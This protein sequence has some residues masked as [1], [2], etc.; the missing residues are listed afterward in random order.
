MCKTCVLLYPG[1]LARHY[2][3]LE[4]RFNERVREGEE[5]ELSQTMAVE[6]EEARARYGLQGPKLK[7]RDQAEDSDGENA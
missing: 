2:K 5:K 7:K 6:T 3:D 1:V 4:A